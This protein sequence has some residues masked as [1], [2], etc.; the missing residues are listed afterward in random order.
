M[1]KLLAETLSVLNG[2]FALATIVAGGVIGK[3]LGP[4]GFR[5]YAELNE[6]TYVASDSQ[7]EVFGIIF[8]LVIGFFIAV[9]VYGLLALFIQMHRE[10]KAIRQQLI[11]ASP[12]QAPTSQVRTKPRIMPTL[13]S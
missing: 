12:S 11:D 7:A 13:N 2:F 1:N 6:L 3:Y 5:L 4:Y 9:A 8:G 10:L